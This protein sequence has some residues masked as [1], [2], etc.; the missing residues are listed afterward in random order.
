MKKI[1]ILIILINVSAGVLCQELT[2]YIMKAKALTSSAKPE[3]AITELT[4]AIR[5]NYDYRLYLQR[6]EAYE[7][8]GDYSSAINDYN[9][10]NDRN[11]GSGEF[12]LSRIYAIK[13]DVQTTL[14]HLDQ[15][16]KS[17]WKRSEKEIMLDPAF[18]TI[19]NRSEWRNFWKKERY[20]EPERIVSEIEFYAGSGKTDE[21]RSLLADL[22]NRYPGSDDVIYSEAFISNASGKYAEAAKIISKLTEQAG[23]KERY[24]R[25]LAGAQ[26]GSSNPAGATVTWSRMLQEGIA[27]AGILLSRAECYR[28][29]G[30]NEK[31]MADLDKYLGLYP[32][33]MNALRLAG[34]TEAVSGDNLKALQLFSK[35]LEL[36]PNEADLYVDRGNSY[37]AARSW[38]WA[39]KDYSMSLDLQ[40]SNS[41]A[42]LNKGIALL[43]TGKKEEACHDFRK[44]LSLGNKRASEMVNRNCIK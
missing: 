30:E 32:N 9:E 1:L 38:E 28:K 41:D 22:K 6:A 27:D 20:T 39:I 16:L 40:P 35:N 4:E 25:L 24:L 8:T 17:S 29:T 26:T 43:N 7:L 36:H 19:E 33:D 18:G 37:L 21:A 12:G 14:Y 34:K 10:A 3:Q 15:N 2:D 42:W 5:S 44:A 31:A 23:A 13:G 11:P